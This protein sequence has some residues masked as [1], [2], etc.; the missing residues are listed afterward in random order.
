MLL[1][2]D[3]VI[4]GFGRIGNW[5]G[6][7][8]FGVEPD[9]DADRQGPV[10]GLPPIGG[11]VVGDRVAERC[12]SRAASSTTATPI[13]AIRCACAVAA[14][15]IAHHAPRRAWSSGCENQTADYFAEAL[16]RAGRPSA[17]GRGAQPWA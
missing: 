7:Q 2:T 6:C 17:G 15:N 4:C 11:V 5:F 8:H 1:V 13:P 12:S 14:E 9:L 10:V 3:E 16:G